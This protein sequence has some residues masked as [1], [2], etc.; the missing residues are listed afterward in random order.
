MLHLAQ[1]VGARQALVV[2]AWADP[3]KDFAG[4]HQV[5]TLAFNS[6]AQQDLRPS[7][8]V[9]VGAID[10]VTAQVDRVLDGA[11]EAV[12][13][14]RAAHTRAQADGRNLHSSLAQSTVFHDR[15]PLSTL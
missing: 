15:A 2:R 6:L 7:F 11:D 14:Q 3:G 13:V 8:A 1:D 12:L 9:V 4:D 10:K 5:V